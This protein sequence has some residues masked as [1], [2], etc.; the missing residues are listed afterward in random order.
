[1]PLTLD[2]AE[3]ISGRHARA[4][5][6]NLPIDIAEREVSEAVRLL[7]WSATAGVP[8]T[9]G[10]DGYGNVLA[11]EI[12]RGGLAEVFTSFGARDISAEQVAANAVA[13]ARDYIAADVPVGP[14][15]ADQ[16]LIPMALAGAGSFVT[17]KPTAH[18]TTNIAVIEKFL[19]VEF[20]VTRLD[21][22]RRWRI[23]ATA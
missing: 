14:H 19:A 22:G 11:L 20:T 12:R 5:V 6:A 7:N 17:V 9:V 1:M 23:A 4:D 10:A 15:L 2:E 21:G 13:E 8:R 18:T 3:P 16:L